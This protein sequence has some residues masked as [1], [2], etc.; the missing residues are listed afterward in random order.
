MAVK[1]ANTVANESGVVS[2]SWRAVPEGDTFA[3]AETGNLWERSVQI[4][5]TFGGATVVLQGSNDGV[6]YATL[7]DL[8][9]SPI[10]FT[11]AG[12]AAIQEN[13]RYVKPLATGGTGSLIDVTLVG[14]RTD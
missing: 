6:T 11:S 5:G 1:P 8:Q 12:L 14:K 4:G 3:V 7:N 9:D 2:V 10:S 13:T